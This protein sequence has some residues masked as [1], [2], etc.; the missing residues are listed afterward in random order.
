MDPNPPPAQTQAQ[1]AAAKR[2]V[3]I[4]GDDDEF[5]FEGVQMS[6]RDE[7]QPQNNV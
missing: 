7:G 4:F 5:K 6:A 1:Q 3:N 2:Q